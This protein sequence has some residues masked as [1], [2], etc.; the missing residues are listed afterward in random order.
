MK[1]KTLFQIHVKATSHGP[2]LLAKDGLPH[3]TVIH[4]YFSFTA[5]DKIGGYSNLEGVYLQAIPTKIIPNTTCHLPRADAMH[6]FRDPVVGDLPWP[7]MTLG[8][9]ILATWYWCTDQARE[10]L[11]KSCINYIQSFVG[12]GRGEWFCKMKKHPL[13][14]GLPRLEGETSMSPAAFVLCT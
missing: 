14:E 2:I 7:G 6:L 4:Q 12:Y 1:K 10:S 9:T 3:F 5:F 13:R 11:Q 8:L